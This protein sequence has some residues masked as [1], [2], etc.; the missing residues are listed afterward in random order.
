ML[1]LEIMDYV[2]ACNVREKKQFCKGFLWNF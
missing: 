1:K 2:Q